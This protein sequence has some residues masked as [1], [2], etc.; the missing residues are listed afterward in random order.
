MISNSVDVTTT[1]TL[2]ISA[3][4]KNRTVYLHNGGTGKVYLGGSAVTTA[5]GFH[6]ANNEAIT[7]ELPQGETLYG[8]SAGSN[9]SVSILFPNSD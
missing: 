8:I 6:L 7:I 2:I 9:Q 4:N 1:A 3:D 5:T